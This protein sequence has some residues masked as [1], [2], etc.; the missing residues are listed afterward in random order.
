ME[1]VLPSVSMFQFCKSSFFSLKRIL[2]LAISSGITGEAVNACETG[3][4]GP[5]RPPPSRKALR[6]QIDLKRQYLQ[7]CAK[8]D[9]SEVDYSRRAVWSPFSNCLF[10]FYNRPHAAFSLCLDRRRRRRAP[11]KFAQLQKL[12]SVSLFLIFTPG[13]KQ[14]NKHETNNKSVTKQVNRKCASRSS[15]L[16][17]GVDRRAHL[18]RLRGPGKESGNS[19]TSRR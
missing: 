14:T 17:A 9:P 8:P 4:L 10:T 2:F 13:R 3:I 11:G 19:P 1:A 15:V 18:R 12:Q 7:P 5:A 16:D 6:S